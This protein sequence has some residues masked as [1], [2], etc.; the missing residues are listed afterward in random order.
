MAIYMRSTPGFTVHTAKLSRD[1]DTENVLSDRDCNADLSALIGHSVWL[2][3]TLT[4]NSTLL[5]GVGTPEREGPE[6]SRAVTERVYTRGEGRAGEVT[7][8]RDGVHYWYC[9]ECGAV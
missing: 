7:L 5:P 1:K 2:F 9:A 4:L 3:F 6:A 8:T